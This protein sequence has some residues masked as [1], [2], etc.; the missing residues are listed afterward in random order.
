MQVRF[1][2]KGLNPD[3]V[4]GYVQEYGLSLSLYLPDDRGCAESDDNPNKGPDRKQHKSFPFIA[5]LPKP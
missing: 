2:P 5:S 4:T 3:K 1:S